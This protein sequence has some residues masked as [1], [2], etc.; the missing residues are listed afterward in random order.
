MSAAYWV[1]DGGP[2]HEVTGDTHGN[3]ILSIHQRPLTAETFFD[4]RMVYSM[5]HDPGMI[6]L[7]RADLKP[8]AVMKS[9]YGVLHVYIPDALFQGLAGEYAPRSGHGPT[10]LIDPANARD[11]GIERLGSEVLAEM[12]S[13]EPLSR[14]RVDTLGQDLTIQLLRR[15]SN[16]VGTGRADRGSY[17]GG[18]AAWQQRRAI[19][20]LSAHLAED[21]ALEAVA[22]VAELSTFHFARAFKRSTGLPPHAY[23]RRLRC[24]R[25]KTL[26]IDSNL[27]VT[28]IAAEVG[29]ETP[30][31]F[32]RMFRAEV[33][34]SPI[35][36]RRAHKA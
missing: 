11:A 23:L 21:V 35:E 27:P 17:I 25:A 32:A 1:N 10:E 33:G 34:A 4:G 31:A 36:Y 5:R 2:V 7:V 24:E 3:H 30:Q 22:R 12:R 8:R 28:E 14:L 29:Y 20:F 13:G 26:L 15:W 16:M 18:L 6:S 9:G 19:E